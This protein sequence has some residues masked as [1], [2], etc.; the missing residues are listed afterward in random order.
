MYN[1]QDRLQQMEDIWNGTRADEDFELAV[2]YY[3]DEGYSQEY[4]EELA[5]VYISAYAD[6]EAR[7]ER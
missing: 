7:K 1:D 2:E 6:L 5:A 4:A 3:I